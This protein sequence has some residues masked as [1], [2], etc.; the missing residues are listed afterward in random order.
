MQSTRIPMMALC[1]ALTLC[2]SGCFF[3]K[4]RSPAPPAA[5]PPKPSVPTVKPAPPPP[6]I[7]TGTQQPPPTVSTNLPESPKPPAQKKVV[8]RPKRVNAQKTDKPTADPGAVPGSESTAAG[9][10]RLGELVPESQ[11][12]DLVAKCDQSIANT[13]ASLAKLAAR[14]LSANEAESAERVRAFLLQAESAK[15]RDPQT[16]LQLAQRAEVL[17]D[18]LLKSLK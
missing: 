14:K 18:D 17:A 10:I 9:P 2:T 5:P 7:E 16:A 1:L 3:R 4:K 15:M 12:A 13:R 11:R 6:K 8:R